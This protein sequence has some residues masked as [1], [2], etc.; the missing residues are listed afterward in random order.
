MN[1]NATSREYELANQIAE[2]ALD[3][4]RI[5][6]NLNAHD[7]AEFKRSMLMDIIATHINGCQLHLDDLLR[8]PRLDFSHDVFGIRAHI[9]RQTGK[10]EDCFVPRYAA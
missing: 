1:W 4:A 3:L 6:E 10:L 7:A 2:R 5:A 8:A 9:N